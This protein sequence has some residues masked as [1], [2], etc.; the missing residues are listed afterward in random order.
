[1]ANNQ[2]NIKHG[3]WSRKEH[4]YLL[5]NILDEW[6]EKKI[7]DIDKNLN[8]FICEGKKFKNYLQVCNKIIYFK[9]YKMITALNSRTKT[10]I[11]THMQKI[12]IKLK[13]A[14]KMDNKN[15]SKNKKRGIKLIY[16]KVYSKNEIIALNVLM[17]LKRMKND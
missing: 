7:Y 4:R 9:S 16:D 10:Q 3:R 11:R 5:S 13:K 6:D 1:M 8:I 2:S 17:N 14:M 12:R 15:I